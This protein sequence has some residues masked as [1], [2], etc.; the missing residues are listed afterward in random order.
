MADVVH[1]GSFLEYDDHLQWQGVKVFGFFTVTITQ[2]YPQSDFP[3]FYSFT[4]DQVPA[5]IQEPRGS[6]F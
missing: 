3:I 5:N 1:G 2:S 4:S 6:Q